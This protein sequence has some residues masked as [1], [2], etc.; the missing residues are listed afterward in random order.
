MEPLVAFSTYSLNA[1]AAACLG[2]S[3]FAGWKCAYF[4]V[5]WA[6]TGIAMAIAASATKARRL[7]FMRTS[8][9]TTEMPSTHV[10][11]LRGQPRDERGKEHEEQQHRDLHAEHGHQVAVHLVHRHAGDHRGHE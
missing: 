2:W 1:S 11:E 9:G 10:P 5:F 8:T 4:S 6:W 3:G 7:S